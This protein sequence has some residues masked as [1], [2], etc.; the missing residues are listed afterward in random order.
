MQTSISFIVYIG[1]GLKQT[2][3]GFQ[4]SFFKS[5]L[6]FRVSQFEVILCIGNATVTHTS[7]NF[8][9]IKSGRMKSANQLLA[10]FFWQELDRN[11]PI[12]R[13]DYEKL[14]NPPQSGVQVMWIGH[15]S[16]LIQFDGITVLTDPIFSARCSPSQMFGG[17]R[18]RDPPCTIDG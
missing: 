10:L 9:I 5:R 11:L 7:R 14:N 18:Y 13:P 17:K 6:F 1:R 12:E 15:A 16:V 4:Q 2:E 3:R 8:L